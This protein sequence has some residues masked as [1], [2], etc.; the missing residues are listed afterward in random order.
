MH[1][2]NTLAALIGFKAGGRIGFKAGAKVGFRPATRI[3]FKAGA[4][5]R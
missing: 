3:G 4:A 1:S 5:S 2:N